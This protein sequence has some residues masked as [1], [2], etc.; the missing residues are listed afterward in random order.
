MLVAPGAAA[1]EGVAASVYR[2]EVA[3]KVLPEVAMIAV[4]A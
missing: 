2:A 1:Q 3:F 4:F